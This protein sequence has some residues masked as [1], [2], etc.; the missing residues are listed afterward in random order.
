MPT[1]FSIPIM[2]ADIDAGPI[3]SMLIHVDDVTPAME[4]GPSAVLF[5]SA[6]TL[7]PISMETLLRAL[8]TDAFHVKIEPTE[9]G[10][11]ACRAMVE[12]WEGES[13]RE[14][15]KNQFAY[16]NAMDDLKEQ[17]RAKEDD[18]EQ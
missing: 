2:R 18:T 12:G 16:D 7:S 14:A 5:R 17:F 13:V 4:V 9:S 1:Y 15:A 8:A 6:G 11:A 3:Y 10:L